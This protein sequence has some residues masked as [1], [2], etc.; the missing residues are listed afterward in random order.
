[1]GMTSDSRRITRAV[2]HCRGLLPH[3]LSVVGAACVAS[4]PTSLSGQAP[5]TPVNCTTTLDSLDARVRRNYAGF[6]L[7]VATRKRAQ[8]AT[9]LMAAQQ[10]ARAA[11]LSTD[12]CTRVLRAYI[13]WYDDPHLFVFQSL[14]ADTA[15]NRRRERALQLDTRHESALRDDFAARC[16]SLDPIE[17]I[18]RDGALRVGVVRSSATS[19]TL[20]AIVLASDTTAWPI[21]ALRARFVRNADGSYQCWLQSRG[22][23]MQQLT[24]TLHRRTLLRFSPG[25]W[26]REYPLTAADEATAPLT[27]PRRPR[28]VVRER[29]VVVIV[30]SHDGPY[31]REIDSLVT[32]HRDALRSAP[33]IIVDLRGNEGGGSMTTRALH[34]YIVSAESRP[35]PYDSGRAVVLSSPEMLAHVRRLGGPSPNGAVKRLI[36]RMEE[37]PGKLVPAYDDVAPTMPTT[38]PL[39]GPWKVAVL[40]DRGTVSA[41][42]VTVL[43]ALR[44]TRATTIG[45]PTAGALDYQSTAIIGLGT[46]DRRWALGFPTITAH[47]D[48]P[49][50]GMRGKGIV[51]HI[52]LRWAE[53]RDSYATVEQM[54]LE[55]DPP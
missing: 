52:L 3:L 10:A 21:G 7:E 22:F 32:A 40:T 45:E 11:A 6:V 16:T 31:Q 39:N 1:M 27:D 20:V 50:R 15:S 2:L 47:A 48:L 36:A 25:M 46:G 19:D 37:N 33:L 30:P 41:A 24:A 13:A 12:D 44:S 9:H 55:R 14:T 43:M 35:T 18:W 8:Y 26:G 34:P 28:L 4:A 23:G 17:G 53:V 42:E 51:P 54:I 49:A 5:S 29:S 38:T